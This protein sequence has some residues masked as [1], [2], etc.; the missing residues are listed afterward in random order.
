MF[1]IY[2]H[3]YSQFDVHNQFVFTFDLNAHC[4]IKHINDNTMKRY[5]LFESTDL[6]SEK[7]ALLY[8]NLLKPL[9]TNN[10]TSS[11]RTQAKVQN[12]LI[13]MHIKQIA[14]ENTEQD[15][16]LNNKQE[17]SIV[18][19]VINIETTDYDHMLNKNDKQNV[20]NFCKKEINENKS[21]VMKLKNILK[22]YLPSIIHFPYSY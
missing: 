8:K 19:N 12:K 21:E 6:F 15:M 14:V 2:H 10:T 9:L 16:I 5:D 4:M 20:I 22:H 1:I 13:P 18:D 17:N 11:S 7:C 3:D